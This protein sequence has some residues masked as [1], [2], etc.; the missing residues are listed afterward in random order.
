MDFGVI[1]SFACT[2]F[3]YCILKFTAK[4]SISDVTAQL[5]LKAV[6]KAWL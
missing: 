5:G 2:L 4:C 1:S 3:L 6:A